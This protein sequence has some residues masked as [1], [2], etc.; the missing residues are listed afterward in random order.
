M[1][2]L[3]GQVRKNMNFIDNDEENDIVNIEKVTDPNEE[4]T[5]NY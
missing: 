4:Q 3:L 5:D 1:A 2:K